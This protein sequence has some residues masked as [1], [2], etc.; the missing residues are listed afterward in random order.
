MIPKHQLLLIALIAIYVFAG[1]F[2]TLF[3]V[4]APRD[5]NYSVGQA[6]NSSFSRDDLP[7]VSPGSVTEM[8]WYDQLIEFSVIRDEDD[9]T[10]TNDNITFF[11]SI[12][13]NTV[14]K[15]LSCIQGPKLQNNLAYAEFNHTPGTER[16]Y[17]SES[18]NASVQYVISADNLNLRNRQTAICLFYNAPDDG[19][20]GYVLNDVVLRPV[21]VT[22]IVLLLEEEKE[23]V[24]ILDLDG[25]SADLAV[26]PEDE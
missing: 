23:F 18:K 13:V 24:K 7:H 5:I 4:T 25:N 3:I 11:T 10:S 6:E 1:V 21:R 12:D 8:L 17:F 15:S 22:E 9:L 16:F 14:V 20:K 2:I 19:L 26:Y